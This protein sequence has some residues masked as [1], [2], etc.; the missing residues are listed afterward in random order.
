M[1]E[2]VVAVLAFIKG[3]FPS[4]LGSLASILIAKQTESK[5]AVIDLINFQVVVTLFLGAT[6]GYVGGSAAV[7]YWPSLNNP[8]IAFFI[9]FVIGVFG[10]AFTKESFI[11][12][13][14][15]FEKFTNKWIG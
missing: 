6:I 13:P 7:G 14:I 9:K 1:S 12:I 11:K 3:I 5:F 8:E 4:T 10:L 2:S 15:L